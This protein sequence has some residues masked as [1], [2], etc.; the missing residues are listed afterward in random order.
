MSRT[1]LYEFLSHVKVI[2]PVSVAKRCKACG[3]RLNVDSKVDY[4]IHH[5]S[6]SKHPERKLRS[7]LGG[8]S[9]EEKR[10]IRLSAGK[11][12]SCFRMREDLNKTLC[13][14]CR[15]K[16]AHAYACRKLLK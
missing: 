10:A 4:C 16:L 2:A 1:F 14:V 6:H 9:P 11:C 7:L 15:K 5:R 8:I 12:V 3:L 13:I